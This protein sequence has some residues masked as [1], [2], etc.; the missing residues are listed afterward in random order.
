MNQEDPFY[1]NKSKIKKE[2]IEQ[3]ECLLRELRKYFQSNTV[4]LK[5]MRKKIQIY[6]GPGFNI[7]DFPIL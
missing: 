6:D 5:S 2:Q 1:V 7:E 4:I 3:Y